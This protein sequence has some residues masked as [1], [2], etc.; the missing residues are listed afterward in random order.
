MTSWQTTT[1]VEEIHFGKSTEADPSYHP[2]GDS[3]DQKADSEAASTDQENGGVDQDKLTDADDA[4]KDTS[5]L[6][7]EKI[8]R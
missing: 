5:G 4:A 3:E 6:T 1:L 7:G 8:E 2:D